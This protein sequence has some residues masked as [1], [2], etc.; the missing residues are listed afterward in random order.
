ME[1]IFW[2][3]A[4]SLTGDDEPSAVLLA[5]MMVCVTDG[6]LVNQDRVL[7]PHH[8]STLASRQNLANAYLDMAASPKR[9][10]CTS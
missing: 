1:S 3:A 8:L 4:G 7:G 5:G 2:H 10:R 6:M 9:S